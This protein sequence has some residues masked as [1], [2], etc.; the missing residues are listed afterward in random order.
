MK[1]RSK[2]RNYVSALRY[3]WLTSLYDPI[4]R[5]LMREDESKLALIEK[6][7]IA[8]GNNILDLG[9]GS[10]TLTI[11]IKKKNPKANVVGLDGDEKIL[12]IAKRKCETAGIEIQFQQGFSFQMAFSDGSIDLVISSLLFHHLTQENKAKTLKEVYRVLKPGGQLLILDWGKPASFF[13][14]GAFFFVQ[15]LDGFASTKDHVSGK[16]RFYIEN[17]GFG[18][19]EELQ[20][21]NTIFGSLFIYRGQ[22]L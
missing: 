19:V 14:R 2:E 5:G 10:A 6:A 15:M 1:A 22:H 18:N 12:T 8:S 13:L 11:L 20:Q 9:C 4:M 3:S 7:E 21:Y 16:L 17:A